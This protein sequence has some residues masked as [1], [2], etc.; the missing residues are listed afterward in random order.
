MKFV[1]STL[2]LLSSLTLTAAQPSIG[3]VLQDPNFS[4]LL[5]A[6]QLTGLDAALV[7]GGPFTVFAPSNAAFASLQAASPGTLEAMLAE[8]PPDTL[9][10]VLLHHVANGVVASS[11]IVDGMMV[12]MLS[13]ENATLT[14]PPA[15]IE[16]SNIVMADIDVQEGVRS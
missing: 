5:A 1:A 4:T 11:D 15:M 10:S 6:L 12:P 14:I 8:D 16:G 3:L 2:A 7:G 13:E 9:R